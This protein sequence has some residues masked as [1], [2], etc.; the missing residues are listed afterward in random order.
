MTRKYEVTDEQ[1]KKFN[2]KRLELENRFAKGVVDPEATSD[3]LQ[4]LIED[5]RVICEAGKTAGHIIQDNSSEL[6]TSHKRACKIMGKNY[7][8]DWDAVKHFGIKYSLCQMAA[9]AKIPFSEATLNELKD[10]H[11]LVAVFPLSI[12]EIRSKVACDL[13][14]K[15]EDAWY[16]EESF[17]KERGETGWQ[18]VRKTPAPNSFSKNWDDQQALLGKDDKTPTVRSMVYTTIG[19]YLATGERLFEHIYVRTS[20][21]D[22]VCYRV[23][24]GDFDSG[25]L[26][27]CD[28]RGGYCD[29]GVSSARKPQ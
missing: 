22:S 27:V 24:I 4:Y 9:L 21:V 15:H 8:S 13:F 18:L 1:R 14:Y 10:T 17:A 26:V 23:R 7:F 2:R 19:H 11:I 3:A 16:N 29:L 28:D 6:M 25:G 20:S 12:L 5:K